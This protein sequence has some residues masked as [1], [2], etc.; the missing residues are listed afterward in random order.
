MNISGSL[1]Q[2]HK[3]LNIVEIPIESFVGLPINDENGKT[4]GSVTSIDINNDL[5]HGT[6]DY[7][8]FKDNQE[9]SVEINSETNIK[10]NS[11][12]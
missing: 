8:I 2:L 6:V 5:W 3:G 7:D 1:S 10:M 4:I 12:L 11:L 9:V